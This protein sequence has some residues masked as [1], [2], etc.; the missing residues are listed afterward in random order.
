MDELD[1]PHGPAD[2]A[3]VFPADEPASD[4]GSDATTA[5]ESTN[6]DSSDEATDGA[7]EEKKGCGAISLA[8]LPVLFL[9]LPVVRKKRRA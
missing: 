5:P 3:L 6:T 9:A 1:L 4:N 7:T 2:A 8:I